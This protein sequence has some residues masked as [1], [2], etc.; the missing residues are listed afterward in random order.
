MLGAGCVGSAVYQ[1]DAVGGSDAGDTA[2]PSPS[3]PDS[4]RT[5]ADT[6]SA[7]E[8]GATTRDTTPTRRRDTGSGS[9][10]TGG[11]GVVNPTCDDGVQNGTEKG[12]DCGGSRCDPC[13]FHSWET[14]PWSECD[15][16]TCEKT[17]E[18]VCKHDDGT[19]VADG[20]C[21]DQK[22]RARKSCSRSTQPSVSGSWSARCQRGGCGTVAAIEAGG[23]TI[24]ITGTDGATGNLTLSN[25][26]AGGNWKE[27]CAARGSCHGIASIA[28]DGS[29]M[30]IFTAGPSGSGADSVTFSD[31][32]LSG[33]FTRSC[34]I[35]N[36]ADIKSID[37]NGS[38]ITITDSDD[39]SSTITLKG[40]QICP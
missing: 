22:P 17:R 30:K 31:A 39:H 19:E 32:T 7:R 36:C 35:R 40:R 26:T 34:G 10:D 1:A 3:A 28:T 2:S 8:T 21:S 33:S 13:D 11:G 16:Q 18:V 15:P 27:H 6:G 9:E 37:A 20:K 29:D 5:T 38:K 14:G 4:D 25:A 12:V 24:T 23:S